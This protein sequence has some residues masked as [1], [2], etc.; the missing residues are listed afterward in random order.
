M[1][2]LDETSTLCYYLYLLDWEIGLWSGE[3]E[4]DVTCNL[5]FGKEVL[6]FS[7]CV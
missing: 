6:K 1:R 5:I 2:A 4:M 3:G 7:V